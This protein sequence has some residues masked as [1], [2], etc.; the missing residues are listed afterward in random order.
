VICLNLHRPTLV[1]NELSNCSP[2]TTK[3]AV[4]T[5]CR[6]KYERTVFVKSFTGGLLL[7]FPYDRRDQQKRKTEQDVKKSQG[8]FD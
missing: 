3:T 8:L 6:L 2:H 1:Y 5:K 4:H 7:T